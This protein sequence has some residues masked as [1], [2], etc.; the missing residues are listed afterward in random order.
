MAPTPTQ[1]A[2]GSYTLKIGPEVFDNTW[3]KMTVFQTTLTIG[4]SVTASSATTVVIPSSASA[5]SARGATGTD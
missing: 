4:Q 1:T 5:N 3:T 2:P